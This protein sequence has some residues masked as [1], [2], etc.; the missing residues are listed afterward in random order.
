MQ[1]WILSDEHVYLALKKHL[2]KSGKLALAEEAHALGFRTL[3]VK[4]A[5]E[6]VFGAVLVMA[7]AQPI[8]Q[9][10]QWIHQRWQVSEFVNFDAL[11][12]LVPGALDSIGKLLVTV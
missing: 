8:F 11:T 6:A 9:A 1:V 3:C 5:E 2:E 10:I 12:A 4:N 7:D